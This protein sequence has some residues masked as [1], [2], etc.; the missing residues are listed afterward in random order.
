V[1]HRWGERI[2]VQIPVVVAWAGVTRFRALTETVSLSGALLRC[3]TI[4]QIP[5]AVF[6]QFE[7]PNLH[8]LQQRRLLAHVVRQTSECIGLEWAEFAPLVIRRLCRK[9]TEMARTADALG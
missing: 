7:S 6:V 1:E 3:A 8:R 4:D 5:A 9:T 2:A